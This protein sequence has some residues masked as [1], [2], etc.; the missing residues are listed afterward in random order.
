MP[1]KEESNSAP[2]L[3]DCRALPV[4]ETKHRPKAPSYEVRRSGKAGERE[5]AVCKLWLAIDVA[6]SPPS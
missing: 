5:H 4:W 1:A 6:P 2:R 3:Q